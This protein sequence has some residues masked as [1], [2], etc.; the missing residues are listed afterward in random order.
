MPV[1]KKRKG[2]KFRPAEPVNSQLERTSTKF[3]VFRG[4][5]PF[6]DTRCIPFPVRDCGSERRERERPG[7]RKVGFVSTGRESCQKRDRDPK[8]DK[9]PR[10]GRID[11]QECGPVVCR[12]QKALR[13]RH[14][15]AVAHMCD[16]REGREH[17]RDRI[18]ALYAA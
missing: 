1:K 10:F 5:C 18:I 11:G 16:C 12:L 2:T 6:R 7:A 15:R 17:S 13:N 4:A 3:L 14:T 9:Y 8:R